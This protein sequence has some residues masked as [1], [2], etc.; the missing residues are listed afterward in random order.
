MASHNVILIGILLTSIHSLLALMVYFDAQDRGVKPI[1]YTMLVLASGF[2]GL[3][4]WMVLRERI[5]GKYR[6]FS[7]TLKS[8]LGA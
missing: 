4:F 8:N 2:F 3:G 7:R 6:K 5:G 1:G